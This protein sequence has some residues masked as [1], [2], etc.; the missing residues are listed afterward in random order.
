VEVHGSSFLYKQ[1][2]HMV[3][4]L[5]AVGG[6]RLARSDLEEELAAG[7]ELAPQA[8]RRWMLADACGLCLAEVHYAR[9][10]WEQEEEHGQD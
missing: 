9:P 3:G 5:L 2:R 6:G 4:A 1:V 8:R 10:L 7:G